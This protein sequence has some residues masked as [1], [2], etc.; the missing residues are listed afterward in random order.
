MSSCRARPALRL[1]LAP[2]S[3]L[4]GARPKASVRD[5]DGEFPNK[6]DEVNMV[7]WEA[8][9]L[10]LAAT[11]GISVPA[12]RIETVADKPV[13]LLRR[14]AAQFCFCYPDGLGL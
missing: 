1:L 14:F 2:G 3:S 5:G 7:L 9:A 4:G 12:W 11:A 10:T 8:I 13:L 6:G